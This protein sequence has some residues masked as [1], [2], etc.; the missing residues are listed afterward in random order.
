MKRDRQVIQVSDNNILVCKNVSPDKSGVGF[1]GRKAKFGEIIEF[2]E[3]ELELEAVKQ[4]FACGKLKIL[5]R[6]FEP[7]TEDMKV[8]LN[9]PE[10]MM[11]KIA[12]LDNVWEI[13]IS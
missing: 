10:A 8:H 9:S 3:S 13:F 7:T 11:N 6:N 12:L 1:Y 5:Y 2:K 4:F